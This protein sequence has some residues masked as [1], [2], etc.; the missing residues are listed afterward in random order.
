MSNQHIELN[1]TFMEVSDASDES[2]NSDYHRLD[3]LAENSLLTWEKLL[4]SRY[5]VI[6]GEAGSGK[7]AELANKAKNLS[8]SGQKAFY[9]LIEELAD[10]K[11]FDILD[12]ENEIPQIENWKQNEN[13]T[14]C[15]F[16]DSL[17]EAKLKRQSLDLAL[18]NLVNA[19]GKRNISRACIVVSCRVSDWMATS[20]LQLFESILPEFT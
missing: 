11:L 18:K 7:S 16:L 13:E 8:T 10:K 2:I 17:D 1:R 3:F 9:I 12:P 15:F 19:L 5:I 4:Q 20:D 14:S 6:L